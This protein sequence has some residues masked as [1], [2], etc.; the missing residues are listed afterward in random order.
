[1]KAATSPPLKCHNLLSHQCQKDHCPRAMFQACY[2]R[3]QLKLIIGHDG[4]LWIEHSGKMQFALL[5]GQ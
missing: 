3:I 1:M 5:S 2:Q 4:L